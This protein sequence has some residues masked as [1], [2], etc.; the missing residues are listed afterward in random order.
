[1]LA[2]DSLSLDGQLSGWMHYNPSNEL[3]LYTGVRY[4]PELN[5]MVPL[6]HDRFLDV[7]VSANIFGTAGFQPFDTMHT[8]GMIKLYRTWVRYATPQLEVRLGLQKINFGSASLLR[9][10]M[11]FDQIDPRDP[12]QLTDGVWGV[13]ARYY[14]LNNTNLWLWTLYGN[15][16][17]KGWES[18]PSVKNIPEYGGRIQVPVPK[19]EMALSY[20]HRTAQSTAWPDSVYQFDRIP[21]NRFGFDIKVDARVGVWLEASWSHFSEDLGSLT[22]QY[23]LNAGWDY[24]FGLGNGLGVIFEQLVAS[25]H[26][27][28]FH[29]SQATTFSLISVTYPVGLF[30][31]LSTIIYYDWSNGKAYSFLNWHRQFNKISL[32]VMG[33][34]NPKEYYIPTQGTGE[35]LYAGT[36][37]Q[38]MAVFHH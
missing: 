26:E 37:L 7:E 32:Y 28:A 23:L 13:L 27:K 19:G 12:L 24:T 4:I 1:M 29:F 33:Y 3:N 38:I 34:M 6:Q 5:L 15:E 17:L 8:D 30:D 35:I 36:G 25:S 11:W 2:Q 9:P 10:L 18:M 16:N 22:N 20:H 21:E 14:F 31:Q